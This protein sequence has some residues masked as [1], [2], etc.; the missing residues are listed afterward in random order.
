M[1]SAAPAVGSSTG[2][3]SATAIR[4]SVG[5]ATAMPTNA[6]VSARASPMDLV[7]L[8]IVIPHAA[9]FG[10]LDASYKGGQLT[11]QQPALLYFPTITQSRSKNHRDK[12]GEQDKQ[13]RQRR[14]GKKSDICPHIDQRCQRIDSE[15]A[16][17]QSG[18]QL[19][20]D[21]DKNQ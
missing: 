12:P 15:R 7:K 3:S 11:W 9:P 21:L 5:C 2:G 16:Q 6:V 19:L 1:A 8:C 4:T 18:G 20:D 17:Q 13:C 14:L 10:A